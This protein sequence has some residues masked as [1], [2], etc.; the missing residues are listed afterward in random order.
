MKKLTIL[1]VILAFLFVPTGVLAAPV[2][3]NTGPTT[4]SDYDIG[5]QDE[6]V[7]EGA[8]VDGYET[9]ITFTD[10]T[11]EDRIITVPDS[12]QTIGTAT[13]IEDELIV[14]ADLDGDEAPADN[15]ILTYDETGANFSWQTP[16]E[17]SLQAAISGTDTHVMFFDGA[18]TP[19]GDAALTYNKGTDTL[20]S[21]VFAGDLTGNADT[22]TFSD[23]DSETEANEILFAGNAAESG[24][25][26]VEADSDFTYNPN[27]GTV[28]ATK[29]AGDIT[30]ALTGNADTVTVDATT[31]DATCFILL[32]E[33]ASGSLEP[34][35]DAT[36][37]YA[38]DTGLFFATI[39]TGEIRLI[40]TDADP[41]FTGEIKHDAT[42]ASMTGGA[43]RWFDNDTARLVVDLETD[44]VEAN[45][46]Y[47]V[48]YDWDAKGFYMKEDSDSGGFTGNFIDHF[49]DVHAPDADYCHAQMT[50]TDGV[51][52]ITTE[53]TSPDVPRNLVVAF[54]AGAGS[55]DVTITGALANGTLAQDETFTFSESAS[56]IG[57][58]AFATV[59]QITIPVTME[60]FTVDVGLDNLLG[61]CNSI[62]EEADIYKVTLD[63][64]DDAD[65]VS[66]NGNADNNTLDCGTI[67]P[68]SDY[69][70]WYS[71]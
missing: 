7:A 18:N 27:T 66:G 62:S 65:A 26:V 20:T 68:N 10:A 3:G 58:K 25:C 22:V 23:N 36:L 41:D 57:V 14:E 64:V 4:E 33:D 49:M 5:L 45:D 52:N 2:F 39:V 61:L 17:L 13:A 53:L 60:G 16:A 67:E 6:I 24:D 28:T 31:S 30:G 44:A 70:I 37:T 21:V 69:T 34:Q 9:I 35:T 50:G 40:T 71:N 48:A 51:Q 29:F 59:T 47:V 19:A 8:T 1:L 15:D 56:V 54:G 12:A 43:L 46:D 63:G 11:T 55:G 38:A 42:V 32:G